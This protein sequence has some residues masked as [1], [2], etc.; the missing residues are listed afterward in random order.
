MD[1]RAHAQTHACVH[2]PSI[3]THQPP[4]YLIPPPLTHSL[5]H[6]PQPPFYLIP[7]YFLAY[8]FTN[9]TPPRPTC[10]TPPT[11]QPLALVELP[12]ASEVAP[13]V[14]HALLADVRRRSRED[15]ELYEKGR[16]AF[17]SFV[18]GCVM[19][20]IIISTLSLVCHLFL[21]LTRTFHFCPP[22]IGSP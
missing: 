6:P 3:S 5:V 4:S 21:S 16:L 10:L 13:A 7:P 8:L 2:I 20:F 12:E 18:R 1:A 15:R 14:D 19:H 11:M 22:L 17:V 9:F